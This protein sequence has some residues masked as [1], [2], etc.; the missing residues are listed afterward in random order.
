[1]T[2]RRTTIIQLIVVSCAV[3]STVLL[4]FVSTVSP[5]GPAPAIVHSDAIDK[6]HTLEDQVANARKS[7]TPDVVAQ[8][9][10]IEGAISTDRDAVRR[11]QMYDSLV[12]YVSINKEKVVYPNRENLVY[13]AWLSEQKAT[14]NNGSGSDWQSAGDRYRVAAGFQQDENNLPA[15]F[16]AAIRCYTKALELEPKNL[17]AMVGLGSCIVQGTNDPMKGISLLLK[18]DSIDSTNVN[19]QLELAQFSLR[20][21]APDKAIV[22]YQ[23]ALRLRPDYYGIHLNLAELYEQMGDTA[24]AIDHLEKYVQIETDP[25]VKNDVENAIRRLRSNLPPPK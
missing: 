9:N 21:N 17:D 14:K 5:E 7:M 2:M 25:L 10:A 1:M 23:R 13:A 4:S 3:I 12:K 24:Q 6:G 16:E 18:V 22:R 11:V 20:R 15:L 19:A 8:V